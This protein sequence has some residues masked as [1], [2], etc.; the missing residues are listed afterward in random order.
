M[1]FIIIPA[2]V[3]QII[4]LLFWDKLVV[5]LDKINWLNALGFGVAFGLILDGTLFFMVKARF[6]RSKMYLD[7]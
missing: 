4:P 5:I 1:T 3:I 6:Q 2:M 7:D